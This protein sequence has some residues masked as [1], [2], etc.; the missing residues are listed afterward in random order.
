MGDRSWEQVFELTKLDAAE[1]QTK[2]AIRLFFQRHDPIAIY[3]IASAAVQIASDLLLAAG[4][5]GLSRNPHLIQDGR[6]KEWINAIKRP[7]NFLKHADREP[8]AILTF[9]AEIVP[10]TLLEASILVETLAQ[11]ALVETRL[12]TIWMM[13]AYPACFS[14]GD[15]EQ[16]C[17]NHVDAH[18]FEPWLANLD[19][20]QLTIDMKAWKPPPIPRTPYDIYLPPPNRT[21]S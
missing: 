14:I 13:K 3:T 10:L 8:D 21:S 19:N 16:G 7:E 1:R 15:L 6:F 2:A 5:G 12:F 4:A 17:L 9:K 11:R 20:P 18:D